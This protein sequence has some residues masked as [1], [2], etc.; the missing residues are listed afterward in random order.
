MDQIPKHDRDHCMSK[1]K[2]KFQ[3]TYLQ[4][5]NFRGFPNIISLQFVGRP[6][7][8]KSYN[9][10]T[11]VEVIYKTACGMDSVRGEKERESFRK[12]EELCGGVESVFIMFLLPPLVGTES[13]GD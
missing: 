9:V 7:K 6:A 5:R 11:L 4:R 2:D 3:Q 8:G 12:L 1:Y 13:R 10:D